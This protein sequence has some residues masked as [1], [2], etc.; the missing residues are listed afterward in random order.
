MGGDT[1]TNYFV[2]DLNNL[3]HLIAQGLSIRESS[4][5]KVSQPKMKYSH[6]SIYLV[7][8]KEW[9]IRAVFQ[10]KSFFEFPSLKGDTDKLSSAEKNKKYP[11]D[12]KFGLVFFGFKKQKWLSKK[13]TTTSKTLSWY[14]LIFRL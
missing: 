2:D 14:C 7:K 9:N 11:L 12:E 4:S 5:T 1:E 13:V 8:K 6:D 3:S 10:V